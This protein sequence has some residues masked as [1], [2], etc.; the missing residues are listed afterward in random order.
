[1]KNTAEL[2]DCSYNKAHFRPSTFPKDKLSERV[3]R[4]SA[5]FPT[6]ILCHRH[7]DFDERLNQ[8]VRRFINFY[9]YLQYQPTI[10]R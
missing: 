10:P 2:R 7:V 4:T 9:S 1:M 5:G 8:K 6:F 3:E